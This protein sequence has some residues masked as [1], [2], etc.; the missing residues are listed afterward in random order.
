M[1]KVLFVYPGTGVSGFLG[2][3]H[4]S[5]GGEFCWIHHGVAMLCAVLKREGHE[6]KLVDLRKLHGWM[7][8]VKELMD[9][10]PDFICISASYLDTKP[11]KNAAKLAKQNFPSCK[12]IVGGL[13]PTLDTHIWDE[14]FI[15]HVVT[16]EG[17]VVL[18]LI[19]SGQLTD[20]LIKGIQPDLNALPFAD[21]AAFDYPYELACSFTGTQETPMITMI[22]A[23]GCPFQCTYCQPAERMVFGKGTRQRSVDHVMG[24]LKELR[25]KYNF[26]SITWWDDTFTINKVWLKEFCAKYKANGF[27]QKMVVCNRADLICRDE[28]TIAMLADAGVEWFVIGFETGTDRLLQFLKKG[29]SVAENIKAAEICRKYGI[30]VFGTFML[31][32]PTE[33]PEEAMNTYQMIKT[34]KPDLKIVFYFTPIPGTEIFSFCK[35]NDLILRDDLLNIDRTA[36]YKPKIKGIDYNF[37]NEILNNLNHKEE[38]CSV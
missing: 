2:R 27:T 33:T 30:K 6:V 35:D 31:G 20:R 34:I 28:E 3:T 16:N 15:D 17:E 11:A 24:E 5:M 25:D 8:Y 19:I 12:I 13:S 38:V 1:S 23:R 4:K 9:M 29:T 36:N 7:D 37:L 14:P 22:S 26:K 10:V 21:R 32:L 18:P